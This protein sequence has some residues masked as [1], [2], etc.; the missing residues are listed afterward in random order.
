M[1]AHA[2]DKRMTEGGSAKF[3]IR[4]E[5]VLKELFGRIP[6]IEEI[7]I[8]DKSAQGFTVTLIERGNETVD[9]QVIFLNRAVPSSVKRLLNSRMV[10]QTVSLWRRTLATHQLRYVKNTMLATAIFQGTA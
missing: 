3:F 1:H 7:Q 2:S 6:A 5:L 4:A 10:R 9:I 8:A